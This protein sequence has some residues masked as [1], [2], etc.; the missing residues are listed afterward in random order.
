MVDGGQAGGEDHGGGNTAEDAE[1]K[2]EL[3]KFFMP[4]VAF[5]GT[6]PG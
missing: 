6:C 2:D 4:L 3:I 1:A 5:L